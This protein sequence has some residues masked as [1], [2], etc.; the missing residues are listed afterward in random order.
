MSPNTFIVIEGDI[1]TPEQKSCL[2]R[3]A[4]KELDFLTGELD[5]MRQLPTR[6][7]AG[8]VEVVTAEIECL[9]AAVSWLWRV[10]HTGASPPARP[11]PV[12]P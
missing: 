7:A 4:R 12:V 10:S 8:P 3:A 9:S 6:Y 11:P 1:L 2:L 5:R